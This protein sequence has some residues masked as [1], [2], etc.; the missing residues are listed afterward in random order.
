[1]LLPDR[2]YPLDDAATRLARA[3]MHKLRAQFPDASA[4][5]AV[6]AAAALLFLAAADCADLLATTARLAKA[7]RG[8]AEEW[9]TMTELAREAAH[10]CSPLAGQALPAIPA[11]NAAAESERFAHAHLRKVFDKSPPE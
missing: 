9:E 2:P 8:G 1:M 7:E 10:W 6:A 11:D 4:R 3:T 5:E